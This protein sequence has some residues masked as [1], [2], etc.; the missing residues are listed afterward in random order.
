MADA[1]LRE[2]G[3]YVLK[4]TT[5]TARA[6]VDAVAYRVDVNSLRQ[7]PGA[8]ELGL[9]DIGRVHIRTGEPIVVDR[10]TRNRNTGSFILIDETTNDTVGAGLISG[11]KR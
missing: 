10:Y 6:L 1:P 11:A 3:R 5:R 8:S 9:N 7:D 2:R 4:H